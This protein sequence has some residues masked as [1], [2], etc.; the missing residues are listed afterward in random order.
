MIGLLLIGIV[1]INVLT[2]SYGSMASNIEADIDTLNNRNA[3][4]KSTETNALSMPR[5]RNAATAAGMV[6]PE[7]ID[8]RYRSFQPG[9]IA[10][11]AQRLAAEGG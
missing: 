8:V 6:V 5:V 1:A 11:A 10:A 7:T 4:L 9:D 3:I 2:V